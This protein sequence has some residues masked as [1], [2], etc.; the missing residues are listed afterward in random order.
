[1][2]RVSTTRGYKGKGHCS[3]RP[4]NGTGRKFR[5]GN[6]ISLSETIET[7]RQ[8]REDFQEAGG[9]ELDVSEPVTSVTAEL[10]VNDIKPET[11]ALGM[12]GSHELLAAQAITD[13]A[14]DAWSGERVT[15]RYI[16]DPDQTI[17]VKIAATAAWAGTT[18]YAVGD[19]VLDT[20]RAYVCTVAGESAGVVPTWPTTAGETVVDGTVTWRDLGPV[21]LTAETHYSPTPQG[22]RFLTGGD[23]L[24]VGD[25]ILPLLVSYTRN[26]QYIIQALVNSGTEY[27][28]ILDG[29]NEVDSGN[30]CVGRYFRV[31]FS[32]TSGFA[33]IGNEFAEL[34]LRMTVLKDENRVGAGLSQYMEFLTI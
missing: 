33:R 19:L 21:T 15:F 6:V 8:S 11:L 2:A 1:M 12:R 14:Q 29:L 13:E 32:P 10:T 7:D 4:L 17:T 28:L 18:A 31:K 34:P 24:F 20:A 5:L 26:P 27:E 3:L 30:P 16:P 23:G 25:S 22:I 9:G